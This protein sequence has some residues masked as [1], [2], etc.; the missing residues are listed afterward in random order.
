MFGV[1][2]SVQSFGGSGTGQSFDGAVVSEEGGMVGAT[3]V[4]A[5]VGLCSVIVG[6]GGLHSPVVD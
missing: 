5:I 2:S 6:T 3:V 1:F 4:G